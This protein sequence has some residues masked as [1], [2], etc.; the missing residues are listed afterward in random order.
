[1]HDHRIRPVD[2]EAAENAEYAAEVA[3][4]VADIE[5]AEVAEEVVRRRLRPLEIVMLALLTASLLVH[6][7]TLTQL[8]RVRNTLRGQIEQLAAGVEAAKSEQVRYDLPIDQQVPIDLDVPI[9]RSLTIPIRTEVRIQQQVNLPIDTGVAGQIDIPIPI[10]ATIPVSTSVPIDFDQ[11]VNISTT[12]PLRLNVPIQ[13]DLGAP[14]IA[15]Y[16]DRLHAALLRLR[17]QL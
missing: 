3:T 16:L 14:Q 8:F 13:V 11:T 4:A 15:G 10:D 1:M 9:S 6:A 12:V 7:L 17:D 5:A 2:D